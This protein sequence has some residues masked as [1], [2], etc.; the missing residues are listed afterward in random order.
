MFNQF[1]EGN[2]NGFL[3][4]T[5]SVAFF[6]AVAF[7]AVAALLKDNNLKVEEGEGSFKLAD[8][9][10]VLKSGPVWLGSIC[11]MLIYMMFTLTT[12]FT[13]YMTAVCGLSNEISGVLTIFRTYFIMIFA[14]IFSGI[15]ADKVFKSTL[16]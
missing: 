5:I 10:L 8:V 12:Y 1:N 16:K 6:V 3:G 15:I 11:M 13:P 7:L 2:G 14:A 9:K 4:V